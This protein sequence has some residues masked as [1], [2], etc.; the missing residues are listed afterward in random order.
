M[1]KNYLKITLRNGLRHKTYSFIN[2]AGLAVGMACGLLILLFVR[3]ELAY[4]RFHEHAHRIYRVA[5]ERQWDGNVRRSANSP[6]PLG[7]ALER[8]FP[9]IENAVRFWRAFQP[10]ISHQNHHFQEEKFYFTD[11]AVF[12]VFSFTLLKGDP[13]TVLMAPHTVV[14]TE[15]IA[16]KYFG[17]GDPIGQTLAYRGYPGNGKLEF[18]VTGVLRNLPGNTHFD[19]DFLAS[20][21]GIESERNNWGSFKPIWTYVLLPENYPP[22]QLENKLPGFV[23]R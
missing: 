13:Q 15:T 5:S 11:P 14:I 10:I 19:F 1:F 20:L 18:T 3:K 2:I 6:V 12:G 23:D 17:D 4:D 8:D 21:Q 16:K 7:P 22:Q 9:E